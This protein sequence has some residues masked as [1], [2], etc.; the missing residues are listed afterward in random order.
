ME[1]EGLV[2][3]RVSVQVWYEANWSAEGIRQ[4]AVSQLRMESR[5]I[6]VIGMGPVPVMWS[7]VK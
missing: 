4:P 1:I 3:S 6:L 2:P 7:R 5:S